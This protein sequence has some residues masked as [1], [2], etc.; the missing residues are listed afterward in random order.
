MG[1]WTSAL[2]GINR[3]H[4][5]RFDTEWMSRGCSTQMLVRHKQAPTDMFQLYKTLV[6]T[7]GEKLCKT[8]GIVRK[9]YRYKWDV[10]PSMCCKL[11][12]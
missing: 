8:E 11:D 4:D 2:D 10:L 7:H 9:S 3:V 1:V 12:Q 5:I 6:H